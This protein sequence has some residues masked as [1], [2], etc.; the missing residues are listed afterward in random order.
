MLWTRGRMCEPL[1]YCSAN[2]TATVHLQ[3]WMYRA[4]GHG[5]CDRID[6]LT[7][8]AFSRDLIFFLSIPF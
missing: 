7:L 5:L 2:P 3:G 6:F 4:G 1:L 8:F